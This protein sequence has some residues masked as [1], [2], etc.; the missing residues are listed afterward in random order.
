MC[1]R[2]AVTKTAS[3]TRACAITRKAAEGELSLREHAPNL[4]RRN[5]ET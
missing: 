3:S 2:F 4:F 5:L 1:F